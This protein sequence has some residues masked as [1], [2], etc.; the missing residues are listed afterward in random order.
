MYQICVALFEI[1][2]LFGVEGHIKE[3][4]HR[5]LYKDCIWAAAK[6]LA[7][8]DPCPSGVPKKV[9][10]GS[11]GGCSSCCFSMGPWPISLMR[12]WSTAPNVLRLTL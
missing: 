4:E 11:H 8:R 7:I 1:P 9:D 3:D 6:A 12:H 5:V 10:T 2:S